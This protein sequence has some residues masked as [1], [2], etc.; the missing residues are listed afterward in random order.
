MRRLARVTRVVA[1]VAAVL[2]LFA[3]HLAGAQSSAFVPLDDAAYGYIDALVARGRLWRLAA[4]E[5]PYRVG[6]VLRALTSDTVASSPAVRRL[7]AAAVA[8]VAKYDVSNVPGATADEDALRIAVT[9]YLFA[10]EETSGIRDLMRADSTRHLRPGFGGVGIVNMGALVVAARAVE[11]T[12]LKD[13]PEYLGQKNRWYVGRMQDAY[14]D[15]QFR[16]AELFAGRLGRN[17]GPSQLDGL[18]IGHYAYSYDHLY[19]KLGVP[20]L[21]LSGVVTR[22][23]D[24]VQSGGTT[25]DVARRYLGAHKL[26]THLGRFEASISEAVVYGGVGEGLRP[27]YA[28]VVTPFILSE[29]SDNNPGNI[30]YGTDMSWRSSVGQFAGQFLLDDVA[31]NSCGLSCQ[32]PNSY[33]YTLQAEGVPLWRYQRLYASYTRV[34]NL[35]YRNETWY[36][37]YTYQTVGLGR[38]YSDYDELRGGVDLLAPVGIPLRVYAAYRRQ[39]EGDYREPHPTPDQYANT[40]QFLQGVVQ[41]T[42]RAAVSG[43]AM[44]G[45]FVQLTGDLGVNRV[46]D[47]QHIPGARTTSFVGRLQL[48]IDS[49]WRLTAALRPE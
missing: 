49:P 14:I 34:A 44:A 24:A 26:A 6:D 13:D 28:N 20:A 47:A 1:L 11:D 39:G 30:L 19:V 38:G 46:L 36:D 2:P 4:L 12:R 9:P 43:T 40:A 15:G 41:R 45:R 35:T 27:A 22:L 42:A 18:L 21:T 10:T 16:Y 25:S 29:V 37:V 33:G 31:K 48:S 7:A 5:R 23:D 32:K 3:P 8:A 17:W